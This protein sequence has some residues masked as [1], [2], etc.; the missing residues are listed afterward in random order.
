MVTWVRTVVKVE[1]TVQKMLPPYVYSHSVTIGTNLVM[2]GCKYMNE[3]K[4][5]VILKASSTSYR[6]S[7]KQG[8]YTQL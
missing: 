3:I 5:L 1:W 4:M 8:I 2:P 6:D 7:N